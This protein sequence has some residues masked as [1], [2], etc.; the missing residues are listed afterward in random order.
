MGIIFFDTAIGEMALAIGA[1][2]CLVALSL[3]EKNRT[4]LRERIEE[5]IGKAVVSDNYLV[6][7]QLVK[8]ITLHLEGKNQSFSDI[9]LDWGGIPK[10]SSFR[11]S[12]YEYLKNNL[13]AGS[14]MTYG[15]V[16]RALGL[17]AAGGGRA[18]GQA[19]ARNPFPLIVPCHRVISSSGYIGGFT[20]YRG[21]ILKQWLLQMEK[22]C[23]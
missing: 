15:D 6:S 8:R 4:I 18:V 1:S 19:L 20:A 14:T 11:K 22:K 10:L 12:L 16:A 17:V 21:V 9:D 13:P 7:S 2:G 3:P 5:R 23:I